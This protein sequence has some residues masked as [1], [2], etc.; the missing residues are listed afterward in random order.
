MN[1]LLASAAANTT[2]FTLD[3][4]TVTPGVLGFLV[5][6]FIGVCLY[7]LMRSMTSRLN[8][9][10]GVRTIDEPVDVAAAPILI[11]ADT[12]QAPKNP[13]DTADGE[14]KA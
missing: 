1:T 6:F 8:A 11:E 13:A 3:K 9:V 10:R 2:T 14:A 7:L 5:I 12:P 4:Y